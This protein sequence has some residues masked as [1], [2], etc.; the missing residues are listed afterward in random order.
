MIEMPEW[1]EQR[2]KAQI[3]TVTR[4]ARPLGEVRTS[5]TASRLRNDPASPET[6]DLAALYQ[7]LMRGS[8]S[9]GSRRG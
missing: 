1:A 3:V 2:R 9:F 7:P 4:N 8:A 5:V 6:S